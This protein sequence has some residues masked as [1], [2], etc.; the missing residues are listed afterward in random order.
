[1]VLSGFSERQLKEKHPR[2]YDWA[3]IIAAEELIIDDT[4]QID[5]FVFL[6]ADGGTTLGPYS[7]IHAGTRV[8]GSG[9]LDIGSGVSVTYNCVLVTEYPKHTSHMGTRVPKERK[10]NHRGPIRLADESF[11]GSGSIIMPDVTLG[12]GAVVAAGSYVTEDVPEWTIQYPDGT[13]APR[14]PFEPYHG[15]N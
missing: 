7:V 8:V 13:T 6:N 4:A 3:R 11:V 10:D 15:K 2:V 12:E 5:D 1:M 9:P 14:E